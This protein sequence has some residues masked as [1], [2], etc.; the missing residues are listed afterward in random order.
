MRERLISPLSFILTIILIN[1]FRLDKLVVAGDEREQNKGTFLAVRRQQDCQ[2]VRRR[3][4]ALDA[5]D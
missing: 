1:I 4:R 3:K 2:G 5:A